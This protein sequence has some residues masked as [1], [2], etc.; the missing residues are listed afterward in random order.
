[1]IAL[2]PSVTV[3]TGG[4][5]VWLS[6]TSSSVKLVSLPIVRGRILLE[7]D[8]IPDSARQHFEVIGPKVEVLEGRAI[9]DG[10]R[11]FDQPIVVHVQRRDRREEIDPRRYVLHLVVA[12][13]DA[14]QVR[15]RSCV[16]R[17]RNHPQVDERELVVRPCLQE[18]SEVVQHGPRPFDDDLVRRRFA[19]LVVL[20][21]E[22]L[23]QGQLPHLD[24][25]L[26]DA[27]LVQLA[28]LQ[29]G[30]PAQVPRNRRQLILG[31]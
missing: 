23:D 16:S 7:L 21:R 4:D 27:V 1:M 9:A 14:L 5:V 2:V 29:L 13:I 28:R 6:V 20:E 19:R 31:T 8:Q 30:A 12:E 15:K 25:D 24:R 11:E 17:K 3:S 10:I 18:P 26:R 22:G